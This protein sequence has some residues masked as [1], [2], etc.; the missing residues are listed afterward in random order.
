MSGLSGGDPFKGALAGGLGTFVGGSNI[1]GQLGI[2]NPAV[3]GAVNNMLASGTRQLINSGEL[4]PESLLLN[5]G[6]D[7]SGAPSWLKPIANLGLTNSS[8]RGLPS[9]NTVGGSP[10]GNTVGGLS[11]SNTTGGL[12]QYLTSGLPRRTSLASR[13]PRRP[14]WET[15]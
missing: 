6:L 2:S 14:S 5:A 15:R 4:N 9:G 7:A 11:N 12:S 3:R 13:Q 8:N 1:G 10:G